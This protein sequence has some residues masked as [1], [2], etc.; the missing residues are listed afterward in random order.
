[1]SLMVSIIIPSAGRRPE[2]LQ[3]AIKSAL[4]DDELIQTEIIVILNG[5]DGMDFDLSQSFQHPLVSYHKIE[6]GNVSKARNYGLKR[7]C[8][9]YIRFLDDDDY[10]SQSIHR[11]Q[12]ERLDVTGHDI[13]SFGVKIIDEQGGLHGITGFDAKYNDGLLQLLN[14]SSVVL[15]FAHL[16]KASFIRDCTWN[17]NRCNAEDLEWLHEVARKRPNWKVYGECVGYWYQHNDPLRLSYSAIN[18][19]ATKLCADQLIKTYNE[20]KHDDSFSNLDIIV[21]NGLWKVIHKAFYLNP[22]YWTK[23]ALFAKSLDK[24]SR[25]SDAIFNYFSYP[26]LI[27]WIMTPKRLCNHFW[28]MLK[29][30]VRN[31]HYIRRF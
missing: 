12:I 9:D 8:G 10:L 14:V 24:N 21:A 6:L 31:T 7:A 1:M 29:G 16:Y 2:L 15:P 28:R 13:S 27:E 4:I 17:E 20:F 23:I 30:K 26:I 5:K 25:P 3:R 22:I 18:Q 11:L 19:E